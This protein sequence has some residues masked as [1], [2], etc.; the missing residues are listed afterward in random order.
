MYKYISNQDT[1]LERITVNLSSNS[2][3]SIVKGASGT[4]K[5]FLLSCIKSRTEKEILV[6]KLEGDYYLRSRDYYP[7][8]KFI[9]TMYLNDNDSV[10]KKLIKDG[11]ENTGKEL[12]SWAPLGN[13]FLSACITELSAINKKKRELYNY[14]FDK[15]ELDILF[16]LEYFC[17]R[18][19]KII[20]LIDDLQYWD[21]KSLSLLYTLIQQ[22]DSAYAFLKSVQF[23]GVV[24]TDY[25]NCDE[26]LNGIIKLASEQVYELEVTR[27]ENYKIVLNQL[28]LNISLNESLI[29]A[30]YSV[31]GGNLQ[32]T[33]D[34]VL[35]LND[36][37]EVDNTIKKIIS[38]KNLGHLLI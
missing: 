24:N 10:K 30:L 28:G 31:T 2:K 38:D 17:N 32:L 21:R 14:I 13:D 29:E 11:I 25:L 19:R 16:P 3:L 20:F 12:G 33:A 8:L 27:K 37:R 1:I 6:Y 5:S 23:V 4:G 7:F 15:D 26:E 34:I 35:L 9:N 22:Q 36:K 18:E